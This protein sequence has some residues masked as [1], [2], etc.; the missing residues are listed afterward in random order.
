MHL[1]CQPQLKRLLSQQLGLASVVSTNEPATAHDV[2][3]PLMSLPHLMGLD[4]ESELEN[5]A[6][7]EPVQRSLQPLPNGHRPSMQRVGF[8]WASAPNSEIAD[9]KSIR[10]I[11]SAVCSIR[12]TA[13][14]THCT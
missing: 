3:A 12:R 9:K 1:Q 8:V 2:H 14:F 4:Q 7:L 10:S 5:P 13:S 11:N 6:Y